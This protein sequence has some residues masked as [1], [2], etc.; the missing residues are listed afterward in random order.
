MGETISLTLNCDR[1]RIKIS[2]FY[3]S[4][5]LL[6]PFICIFFAFCTVSDFLDFMFFGGV[7]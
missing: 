6:L 7:I 1:I 5:V 2:C 3:S 4:Q